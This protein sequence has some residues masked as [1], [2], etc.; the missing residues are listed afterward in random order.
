MYTCAFIDFENLEKTIREA[1]GSVLDFDR[2]VEVVKDVAT[3]GD[4]RSVGIFAHGDFDRGDAGL[5]TRLIRLGIE[6]RHVVTKTPHQY[7]KGSTDIELSLDI[8]QTMYDYP[9]ITDFLLLSG[10]GDLAHVVRR[11][12]LHGKSVRLM[13]FECHTSRTVREMV[14]HF[15]ALDDYPQI[16]RKVTESERERRVRTLLTNQNVGHVVRHLDYCERE[17]KKDFIGLNYFRKRLLDRYP[18]VEISEALSCALEGGLIQS[19]PVPNPEDPEHPTT[20]CVLSRE[21]DVV[22]QMLR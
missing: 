10:D 6:P 18:A 1:F 17:L 16:M 8:L 15:I 2:F 4:L 12:M 3:Q 13:G 21:N 9:H 11:L 20:A 7:L 22:T 5:Q 14:D 19:Y